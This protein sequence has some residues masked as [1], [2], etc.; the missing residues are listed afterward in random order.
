MKRLTTLLSVL[1]IAC[2]AMAQSVFQGKDGLVVMESES[3]TSAKG[4]WKK[5]TTVDGYTGD[6]HLEFTGNKPAS[7][8][9]TSPLKYRFKVDKDG[10]YRLMIRAHKRLVDDKGKKARGDHCNDCYVRIQGRYEAGGGAPLEILKKDTKTFVH[11]KAAETWDWTYKLDYHDPKTHKG[12]KGDP[13]YKLKAGQMYTL[14]VSG[15][16]Q[17]FNMDRIVLKHESVSM[18][19]AKDP[20]TPEGRK[21]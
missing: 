3:S 1:L 7:G 11:G 4:E 12:V 20:E 8:P 14:V 6:C 15:R 5:K 18:E 19:Q 21:Q 10:I 17:R 16:S 9:A 13:L 2:P